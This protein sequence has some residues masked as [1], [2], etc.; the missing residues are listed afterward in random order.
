MIQV[1]LVLGF[2]HLKWQLGAVFFVNLALELLLT[3]FWDNL[4]VISF[5]L[6][7]RHIPKPSSESVFIPF[8][9]CEQQ[10]CNIVNHKTYCA[11]NEYLGLRVKQ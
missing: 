11:L 6:N 8:F 10:K 4:H 3:W 9:H 5:W 7:I 2:K 1:G